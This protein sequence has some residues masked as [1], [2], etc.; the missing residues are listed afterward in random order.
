MTVVLVVPICPFG[1]QGGLT[2]ALFTQLLYAG[3]RR[4]RLRHHRAHS[5]AHDVRDGVRAE[6]EEG[7]FV[8]FHRP[9]FHESAHGIQKRT[10]ALVQTW[11]VLVVLGVL[12]L[13][14]TVYLFNDSSRSWLRKRIRVW[15][16]RR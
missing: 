11:Q 2:G 15:C 14:G 10:V 12:L 5:L 13:A 1:F 9:P 3:R 16:C 7:R 4:Y 8:H 6:Q